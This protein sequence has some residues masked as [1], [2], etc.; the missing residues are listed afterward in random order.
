MQSGENLHALRKSLDLIRLGSLLILLIHYC[1]CC[2]AAW[3][4][5]GL[6]APVVDRII[7]NLSY[8]VFFL[9]GVQPPKL[10]SLLLLSFSLFGEKGKKD[11]KLTIRPVLYSILI[12]LVLFFFVL[13]F[14]PSR[15]TGNATGHSLHDRDLPRLAL[16]PFRRCPSFPPPP[17]QIPK[18]HLQRPQ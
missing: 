8:G 12:G 5:W 14:S 7:G 3:R 16:D 13:L 17:A 18:G 11:D 15:Y 6:T 9:A 10:A 1:T 2:Y 4:Q